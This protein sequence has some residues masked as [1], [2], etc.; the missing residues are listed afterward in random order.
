[1]SEAASMSSGFGGPQTCGLSEITFERERKCRGNSAECY[2][3]NGSKRGGVRDR[4]KTSMPL[5]GE[6]EERRCVTI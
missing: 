2:N 4:S 1:M 3:T 5:D 6:W